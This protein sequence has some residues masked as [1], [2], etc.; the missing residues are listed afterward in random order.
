MGD[1]LPRAADVI[2]R[3][4]VNSP[5]VYHISRLDGAVQYSYSTY[6]EALI[7]ATA[8]ARSARI[9]AWYSTDGE[10]FARVATHR[11]TG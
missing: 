5:P 3:R 10:L 6:G 4:R 8:F 11:P 7:A 9:D 1:L 2:I